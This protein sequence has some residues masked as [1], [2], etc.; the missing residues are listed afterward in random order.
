[1]ECIFG[2]HKLEAP[3][4]L[5]WPDIPHKTAKS[6]SYKPGNPFLETTETTRLRREHHAG[7]ADSAT[8]TR[9]RRSSVVPL[10]VPISKPMTSSSHLGSRRVLIER[11]FICSIQTWG[12]TPAVW[13][14]SCSA[15]FSISALLQALMPGLDNG[16]MPEPSMAGPGSGPALWLPQSAKIDHLIGT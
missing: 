10:H 7:A 1:M 16:V 5:N 11:G 4:D 3:R 9:G 14:A 2:S 8:W 13:A 6:C 15:S 12:S